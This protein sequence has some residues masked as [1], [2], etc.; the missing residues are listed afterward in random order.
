MKKDIDYYMELDY[1]VVIDATPDGEYF[2]T[3][4]DLPG[5]MATAETLEEA[6]VEIEE[7]KYGW[8]EA[9]L[10]SDVDIREPPAERR[11]SGRILFR[12]SP[13][14]HGFLIEESKR[15][16][17]TLN[18]YLNVLL[19]QNRCLLDRQSIEEMKS[20]SVASMETTT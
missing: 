7:A 14:I 5:C 11:F 1:E 10:K 13:A 19:T 4:P 2:A 20:R 15:S 16:G 12:T 6:R 18:T 3:I 8:L 17:L 9:A